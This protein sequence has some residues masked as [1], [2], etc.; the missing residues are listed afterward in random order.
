MLFKKRKAQLP[1]VSLG[2]IAYEKLLPFPWVQYPNHYG[3]IFAFSEKKKGEYYLCKCN[4]TLLSNLFK[5]NTQN[6][7][8][9]NVNA[10]RMASLDSLNVPDIIAK[11][12]LENPDDPISAIK[13]KPNLCHR[14]NLIHPTLRYCHEMYGGKFDQSF[15][16][17]VNQS[18]LRYGVD[19]WSK[20]QFLNEVCPEEIK[21]LIRA[22]SQSLEALNNGINKRTIPRDAEKE[23]KK[24]FNKAKRELKNTFINFTREEFGFRKVGER[25]IS[26][27]IVFKIVSSIFPNHEILRHYRPDWLEKLELDIFLPNLNLGIEYQGQQHFYPIKA[28]GGDVAFK[29]LQ[30]RDKKKVRIC[31]NRN[32]KLIHINYTDPLTDEFIRNAIE[33]KGIKT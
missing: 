15:G 33:E 27:T 32:I 26:E 6:A 21:I 3:T 18:Y 14:C 17:Y 13:F 19:P 2:G 24:K 5:L 29:K 25:W 1:P 7:P 10:Y 22:Y 28:W 4:E 20:T 12:A 16:W 30:E 8:G 11:L 23:L 31:K 9:P